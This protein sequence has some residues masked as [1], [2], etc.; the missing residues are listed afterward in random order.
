L[1]HNRP[2]PKGPCPATMA[3]IKK[4]MQESGKMA[5]STQMLKSSDV[6]SQDAG[7][8]DASHLQR[9]INDQFKIMYGNDLGF[10]WT[11]PSEYHSECPIRSGNPS[12]FW[13]I[14]R[15]NFRLY[16]LS[17]GRTNGP[18]NS[19]SVSEPRF[20]CFNNRLSLC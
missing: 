16:L 8:Q 17:V 18:R 2:P 10:D 1:P 11:G 6:V 9:R 15:Y 20:R 14:A 3:A 4:H 5:S 7:E 12:D 19:S 13:N